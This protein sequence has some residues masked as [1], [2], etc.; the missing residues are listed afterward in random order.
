MINHEL[1]ERHE[2]WIPDRVGNDIR[3]VLEPPLLWLAM[4]LLLLGGGLGLLLVGGF[5]FP[6]LFFGRWLR[7]GVEGI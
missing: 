7:F 5:S 1:H 3:L 4:G 2:F 6:V